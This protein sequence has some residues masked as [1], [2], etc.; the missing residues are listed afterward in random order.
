MLDHVVHIFTTGPQTVKQLFHRQIGRL[1]LSTQ[2]RD[3]RYS[4]NEE[5]HTSTV[6][7]NSK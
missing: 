6:I 5:F 2:Q 3:S 1:Q 4:H 7:L